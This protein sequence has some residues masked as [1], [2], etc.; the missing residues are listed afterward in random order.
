MLLPLKNKKQKQ[1]QNKK[2]KKKTRSITPEMLTWNRGYPNW[3]GSGGGMGGRGVMGRKV[4]F[5]LYKMLSITLCKWHFLKRN[6]AYTR[7]NDFVIPITCLKFNQV[8]PKSKI[9]PITPNGKG[10]QRVASNRKSYQKVA[11][12]LWLRLPT[13]FVSVVQ[14]TWFS[15]FLCFYVP[16][17]Y[18]TLHIIK[19]FQTLP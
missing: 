15:L 6:K 11:N 19:S 12:S 13:I 16:N 10:C 2:N 5:A 7:L 18:V 8:P 17:T 14:Y 1:K 3:G 4:E 9:S